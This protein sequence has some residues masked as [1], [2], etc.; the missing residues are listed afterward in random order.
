MRRDILEIK[1]LGLRDTYSKPVVPVKG[2]ICIQYIRCGKKE[3]KCRRGELHGPYYYHVWREGDR[4]R[5]VYV[6]HQDVDYVKA[7][8]RAYK[9]LVKNRSMLRNEYKD[10]TRSK[11]FDSHK[12]A[13]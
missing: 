5:K 12:V 3:C 8:C 7:C 10:M 1:S 11:Q 9:E 6:K 4:V 2:E 13:A